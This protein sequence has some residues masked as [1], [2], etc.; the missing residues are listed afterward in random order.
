MNKQPRI[1]I[2]KNGAYL[3]SGNVPLSKEIAVTKRVYPI[4]WKKGE[5]YPD[6]ENYLLC[7]CGKSLK[8]P[9]CDGTHT[10]CG[11]DGAETAHNDKYVSRA[12]KTHGPTLDLTDVEELCSGAR[13]CDVAG[14]AWTLTEKSDKPQSKQTAIQQACDC[15]SGRLVAWDPSTGTPMEPHF[16]PSISVTEDPGANVS[17]PLWVKG[18]IPVVSENGAAYE[19]RNRVTLCRCGESKNKPFCDGE[20]VECKFQDGDECLK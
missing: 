9:Y 10:K 8:K 19:T 2:K 13:F 7:R 20:H 12:E 17:G 5:S 4:K 14:G 16:E 11:F 3:V 6:R 15:P 1:L 18:G